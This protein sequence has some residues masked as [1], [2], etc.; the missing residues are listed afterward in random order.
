MGVEAGKIVAA[1]DSAR[2]A[3][4]VAE[5]RCQFGLAFQIDH[6]AALRDEGRVAGELNRVTE[7]LLGVKEN[8][9]ARDVGAIP[10]RSA[11]KAALIGEFQPAPFVFAPGIGEVGGQKLKQRL[12]PMAVG[13]IGLKI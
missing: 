7:S 5:K 8:P 11:K 10:L 12:V 13:M 4:E 6:S 1:R 2:D 3:G 9:F